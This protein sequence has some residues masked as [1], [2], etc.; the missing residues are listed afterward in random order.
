M[1]VN[2]GKLQKL[3]T[4]KIAALDAYINMDSTELGQYR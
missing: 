1:A 4:L 3:D 2:L